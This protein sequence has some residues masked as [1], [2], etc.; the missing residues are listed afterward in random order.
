MYAIRFTQEAVEEVK[1]L[2]KNVRNSLRKEIRKLAADPLGPSLEL[3]DPLHGWRSYHWQNYR[4][5]F[6]VLED[7][8]TVAIAAVGKRLPGS[9]T[10]IYRKLERLARE[11]KLADTLLRAVREFAP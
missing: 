8:K 10:D 11:G 9:Q 3:R 6:R 7:W 1:A 5:V 4:I 2:P